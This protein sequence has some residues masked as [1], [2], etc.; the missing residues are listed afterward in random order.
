M[1]VNP[2]EFVLLPDRDLDPDPEPDAPPPPDP[3]PEPEE[4][5]VFA[6]VTFLFEE[7]LPDLDLFPP[8]FDRNFAAEDSLGGLRSDRDDPA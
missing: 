1:G 8:S 6:N 4:N 7:V 3:E 5:T 2:G